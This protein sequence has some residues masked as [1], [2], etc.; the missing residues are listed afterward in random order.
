MEAVAKNENASQMEE[1]KRM[2]DMENCTFHPRISDYSV[3]NKE[4]SNLGVHE[5]LYKS[6]GPDMEAYR[7]EKEALD[8]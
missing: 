5:R 1:M 2:H 3:S 4:N 7:L 6:K 8:M